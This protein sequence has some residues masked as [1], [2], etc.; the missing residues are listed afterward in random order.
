L[1]SFTYQYEDYEGPFC[2]GA[3]TP[4]KAT[5]T[6]PC[7][8]EPGSNFF[9]AYYCVAG[10]YAAPATAIAASRWD[11]SDTQCAPP[12]GIPAMLMNVYAPGVCIESIYYV[13]ANY[14]ASQR[15]G[16]FSR[17]SCVDSGAAVQVTSYANA[18][19]SDSGNIST[20]PLCVFNPTRD[21]ERALFSCPAAPAPPTTAAS[22]S[23]AAPAAVAAAVVGAAAAAAIAATFAFKRS[24]DAIMRRLCGQA[25]IQYHL[26]PPEGI[27][28]AYVDCA[29]PQPN[30]TSTT[31]KF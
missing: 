17:I 7:A 4:S 31:Y 21:S 22:S 23:R 12:A 24:R 25:A 9:S 14:D 28:T 10:T 20:Y 13:G 11:I 27:A 19:C 5:T 8:R 29:D 30:T 18:D 16:G 1:D 2:T 26:A 6:R 15:P 3:F